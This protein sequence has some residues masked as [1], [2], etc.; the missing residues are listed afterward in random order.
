MMEKIAAMVCTLALLLCMGFADGEEVI[1]SDSPETSFVIEDMGFKLGIIHYVSWWD[2]LSQ[3]ALNGWNKALKNVD[4]QAGKELLESLGKGGA[5]R[6]GNNL[7][8]MADDAAEW[9]AKSEIG[10]KALKEWCNDAQ[11]GLAKIFKKHG[12]GFVNTLVKRYKE[13]IVEITSKGVERNVIDM[14]KVNPEK[15]AYIFEGSKK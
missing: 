8:E 14:N 9:M 3:T 13:E 15:L 12:E 5:D 7:A 1:I 2:E 11:K 4:K 10:R 6:A